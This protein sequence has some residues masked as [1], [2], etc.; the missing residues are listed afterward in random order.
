MPAPTKQ[1]QRG[2]ASTCRSHDGGAVAAQV[3]MAIPLL[4]LLPLL[5]VQLALTS[6]ARSLAQ[7]AAAQALDATRLAG[8][9]SRDGQT[10]ARQVLT[11]LLGRSPLLTHTTIVITRTHD[12]ATVQI[13]G[14]SESVIPGLNV[15]VRA[16][17]EGPVETSTP[18]P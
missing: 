6:Y 17:T 14:T 11:Q 18:W 2:R 15:T 12:R 4:V 13:T 10:R 9:T 16:D 5:T 1:Q 7:G 3:V 8:A